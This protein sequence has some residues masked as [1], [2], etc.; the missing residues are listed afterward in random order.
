MSSFTLFTSTDG[1]T[2]STFGVVAI[3]VAA[4]KS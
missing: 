1:L 3:S 4:S 2:T